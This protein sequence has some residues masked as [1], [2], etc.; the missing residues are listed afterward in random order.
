MDADMGSGDQWPEIF[1]KILEADIIVMGTPIWNGHMSSLAT[2]VMERIYAQSGE[3]A[4]NGQSVYYNK[5]FGTIVTGNE[6][7]AKKA[8]DPS[9]RIWQTLVLQFRQ[10]P[11][12]I[13]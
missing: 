11:M 12:H 10:T 1:K 13:G 8:G 5:V 3:T 2:L 7:G 6:D 4:S 9:N